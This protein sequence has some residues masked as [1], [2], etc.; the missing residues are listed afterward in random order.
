MARINIEEK[1][2]NDPRRERL[3]E[4]LGSPNGTETVAVKLWRLSQ[5]YWQK[6]ELIPGDVFIHLSGAKALIQSGL[7]RVYETKK[8]W[9][10]PEPCE[11]Y[12][13]V[14]QRPSTTSNDP[15]TTVNDN[16]TEWPSV[17]EIDAL[18]TYFV[19]ACGS[20]EHHFWLIKGYLQR[21]EAGR[22]SAERRKL[23]KGTSQP[24]KKLPEN[25]ER[26]PVSLP[27]RSNETRTTSNGVEPS[28]SSSF[29]SSTSIS[30]KKK[31][32]IVGI[33]VDYP[34]E[35][36][37]LWNSYGR[38]GDKKQAYDEY[39][40]LGLSPGEL[41]TLKL[42]ITVYVRETPDLQYRKHFFR[43]LR[44]DWRELLKR[45]PNALS[46]GGINWDTVWN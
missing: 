46:N 13:N 32:T 4:Y 29:S 23:L 37:E 24:P 45:D 14:P 28:I 39:S 12:P 17:R 21:V 10:Y 26:N 2:W 33:R 25:L 1:W 38:R 44:I 20:R 42:A 36:D 18:K 34:Q 43:F 35:F 7:V 11:Q 3:T 6:G 40:K 16:P 31:N 27:P 8:I 5:T 41:E 22:K 15:R 19:Y 9:P 30:K